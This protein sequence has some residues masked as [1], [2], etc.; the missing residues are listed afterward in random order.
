MSNDPAGGR[1]GRDQNRST[2]V[3]GVHPR[4]GDLGTFPETG[5]LRRR[6]T[7]TSFLAT[8]TIKRKV[9]GGPTV[10]GGLPIDDLTGPNNKLGMTSKRDALLMIMI[11]G[12]TQGKQIKKV[13]KNNS[14]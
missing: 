4:T 10:R 8:T 6:D 12:I 1:V 2:K 13:R 3:P 11:P 9:D 7:K 14:R 5:I